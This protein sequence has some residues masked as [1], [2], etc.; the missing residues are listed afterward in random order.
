MINRYTHALLR[1]FLV[2]GIILI[3]TASAHA[4]KFD[5]RA[6]HLLEGG[7]AV[8]VHFNDL[9]TPTIQG[10]E[11]EY[12][13]AVIPGLPVGA[14]S[15]NVKIVAAGA[16]VATP[17]ITSDMAV[18][19]STDYLG[20]AYGASNASSTPKFTVLS[21]LKNNIPAAGKALLRVLHASQL[22]DSFD[23]YL[24]TVVA[25]QAM[26]A[27]IR[28]DSA[29]AF[30]SVDAVAATLIITRNGSTQPLAQF[31]APLANLSYTTLVITGNAANN[32]KVYEINGALG[33]TTAVKIPLL[34]GASTPPAFI[35]AVNAWPQANV[36]KVDIY[37]DGNI[38]TTK[39]PYRSAAERYGPLTAQEATLSF[40]AAGENPGNPLLTTKVP[41]HP[42]TGY[43]VVLTQFDNGGRT[44]LLMRRWLSMKISN[45]NVAKI[46]VA[47]VTDFYGPLTIVLK[48]S[49]ADTVMYDSVAF[50][51]YTQYRDVPSG[52]VNLQVFRRGQE[53]P[54]YTGDLQMY[55][56]SIVTFLALGDNLRF[57]VD[58]LNDSIPTLQS[59][60]R[61]FDPAAGVEDLLREGAKRLRLSVVPNPAS[62]TAQAIFSLPASGNVTLTIYDAMGQVVGTVADGRMEEGN[63]AIVLP[64]QDLPAGVYSCVVRTDAG[65]MAAKRVVVAK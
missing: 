3:A 16:G 61:S 56:S 44:H 63:Q 45:P 41:L 33:G 64:L 50:L 55:G 42:D 9:A 28:P 53:T 24:G 6:V 27:N 43:A 25:G 32:L 57:N 1:I 29:T 40:V 4:Q 38:R 10:L 19:S 65:T 54:I 49:G 5:F 48:P 36:P 22:A 39:L 34:Q 51:D 59:P 31:I 30:K 17:I 7:G 12:M 8:D 37:F 52:M 2:I 13:S 60:M 58:I 62:A 11:S 21:R 14:G 47:N 18:A 15:V 26:F 23:I 20:I 46:R 35:R